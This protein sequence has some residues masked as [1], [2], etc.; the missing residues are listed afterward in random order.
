MPPALT[1]SAEGISLRL[2]VAPLSYENRG[3]A[4]SV[5]KR[6]LTIGSEPDLTQNREYLC[7][8][9]LGIVRNGDRL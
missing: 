6:L 5:K 4:E 9:G 2:P 3:V 1:F 7:G 8:S